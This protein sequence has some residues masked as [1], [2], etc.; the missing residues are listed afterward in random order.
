M[1]WEVVVVAFKLDLSF[2]EDR[3]IK[4]KKHWHWLWQEQGSNPASRA[5]K[6]L[7]L[8]ARHT[9]TEKKR[10]WVYR[11]QS[12]SQNGRATNGRQWEMAVKG[13]PGRPNCDVTKLKNKTSSSKLRTNGQPTVHSFGQGQKYCLLGSACLICGSRKK[14][15]Y[16]DD[17]RIF[18]ALPQNLGCLY[19]L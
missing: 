14:R 3:K 19:P 4:K 16:S 10:W 5:A 11:L 1:T 12:A 13:K 2:L 7:L 9:E 6:H 17:G 8:Q 18:I 15:N